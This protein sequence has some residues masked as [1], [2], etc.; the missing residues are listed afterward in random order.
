MPAPTPRNPKGAGRK[1]SPGPTK[2]ME[3]FRCDADL[4]QELENWEQ[5]GFKT[6]AAMLN[7]AL[8]NFIQTFKDPNG[9]AP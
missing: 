6:K 1:P 3:S 9:E 5:Y 4:A 8:R 2:K 7:F